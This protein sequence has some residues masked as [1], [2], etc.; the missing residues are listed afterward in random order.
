MYFR[1]SISSVIEI[2]IRSAG[3][4]QVGFHALPDRTDV[5]FPVEPVGPAGLVIEFKLLS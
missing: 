5:R 2:Q 1:R 4:K 3:F